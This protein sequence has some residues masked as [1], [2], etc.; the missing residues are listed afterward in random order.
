MQRAAS[1]VKWVSYQI[2]TDAEELSPIQ[3]RPAKTAFPS[4]HLLP[5]AKIVWGYLE[6]HETAIQGSTCEF[7]QRARCLI[8][9]STVTSSW[10]SAWQRSWCLGKLHS[11]SRSNLDRHHL[12]QMLHNLGQRSAGWNQNP[13]FGP[14]YLFSELEHKCNLLLSAKLVYKRTEGI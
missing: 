5:P 7:P 1:A 14:D 11:A 12:L 10:W 9:E 13:S 4:A 6:C 2:S 3:Y 8:N